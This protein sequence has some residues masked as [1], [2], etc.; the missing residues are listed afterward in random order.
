MQAE[1]E[2]VQGLDRGT[3]QAITELEGLIQ[4]R[5]P[6]AIFVVSQGEDPAGIYLT[7]TVDVEDTDLVLDMVVDR[8][9]H[10]Q[11]E[12][13]LPIY[14]VPVRPLRRAEQAA[15]QAAENRLRLPVAASH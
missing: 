14:V 10:L 9:L 7:A 1:Y 5:Y 12:E 11:V 3:Q 4:N 6:E 13:Q 8:L 15:S 2:P